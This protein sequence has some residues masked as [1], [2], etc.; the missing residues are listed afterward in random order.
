MR[1]ALAGVLVLRSACYVLHSA[2]AQPQLITSLLCSRAAA[3]P[4]PHP[5]ALPP[6]SPHAHPAGK[7]LA[8]QTLVL[9]GVVPMLAAPMSEG[10]G[11]LRTG[12]RAQ[13]LPA[14]G[15][16]GSALLCFMRTLHERLPRDCTDF[17]LHSWQSI[18]PTLLLHSWLLNLQVLNPA[19][20]APL[21]LTPP[22]R[23]CC[24]PHHLQRT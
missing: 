23:P 21:R 16:L 13:P 1:V 2:E 17:T 10:S 15:C 7:Y 24:P 19:R 11:A 14:L 18:W 12:H 8:R 9:R 22:A 6:F 3:P 5:P 20:L 4:P